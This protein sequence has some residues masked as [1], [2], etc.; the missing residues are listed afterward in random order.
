MNYRKWPVQSVLWLFAS[1]SMFVIEVGWD[2]YKWEARGKPFSLGK[3]FDDCAFAVVVGWEATLSSQARGVA[4]LTWIVSILLI[5]IGYYE[6][7]KTV[8]LSPLADATCD[9]VSVVFPL[10]VAVG[11]A[12]L[13]RRQERLKEIQVIC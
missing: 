2:L 8:H 1:V 3:L 7:E 13:W 10:L 6:L 12:L 9:Q 4:F 11:A 5:L